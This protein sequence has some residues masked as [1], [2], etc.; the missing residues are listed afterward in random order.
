[1]FDK[2]FNGHTDEKW[3]HPIET[4][5][6]SRG[7]EVIY[8]TLGGTTEL[9]HAYIN[10]FNDIVQSNHKKKSNHVKNMC[11]SKLYSFENLSR[12]KF[13]GFEK[14]QTEDRDFR[15]KISPLLKNQHFTSFISVTDNN[16]TKISYSDS[17]KNR[18][19]GLN[20]CYLYLSGGL[21]SELVAMAM[22]DSKINFV[23]VIF[24]IMKGHICKNIHDVNYA[25]KFCN[26]HNLYP[27]VEYINI[28]ELWNSNE[29][30]TMAIEL[31]ITSPQI[32][33]HC[34]MVEV[35]KN[36][37]SGKKHVFGGEVRYYIDKKDGVDANFVQLAKVSNPGY[38]GVTYNLSRSSFGLANLSFKM[39]STGSWNV[40]TASSGISITSSPP[41][42]PTLGQWTTTPATSYEYQVTNVNVLFQ[43]SSGTGSITYLPTAP[44]SWATIGSN[45]TVINQSANL[46]SV[47]EQIIFVLYTIEVRKTGD[48]LGPVVTT[49]IEF[50]TDAS[51]T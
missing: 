26:K 36:K 45:T 12:P 23:P 32:V 2:I 20:D 33:T 6:Q 34:H 47:G 30:E 1:M 46:S 40:I 44:T 22:L 3:I 25:Y 9:V 5:W 49:S 21:D 15:R 43:S 14:V 50:D 48:T 27:I 18:V 29:F 4:Y 35:I 31:G 17:L 28:D 10:S 13:T 19:R 16:D 51:V 8:N 38:N 24:Q 7:V 39:F 41:A 37:Y 42:S 11:Y